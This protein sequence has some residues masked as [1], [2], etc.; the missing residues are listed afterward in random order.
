MIFVSKFLK[1]IFFSFQ[2][3]L[4]LELYAQP[5]AQPYASPTR[6]SAQGVKMIWAVGSQTCACLDLVRFL[7]SNLLE[8]FCQLISFDEF[9]LNQA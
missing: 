8:L 5:V 1:G 7:V 9:S 4:L 3:N 2:L 6:C